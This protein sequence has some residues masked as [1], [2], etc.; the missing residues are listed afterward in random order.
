MELDQ[1]SRGHCRSSHQFTD[2]VKAFLKQMDAEPLVITLISLDFDDFNYINDLYSYEVGDMVLAQI[3]HHIDSILGDGDIFCRLHADHFLI[4]LQTGNLSLASQMFTNVTDLKQ[5]LTDFLPQHYTLAASGGIL[6]V[7]NNTLPLPALLDQA[8][9]A[10]KLSKGNITNSFHI[11]DQ[12]MNEDTCWRKQ[13]TCMM[14]AALTNHEF[15]MYLQPKVILKTG[16]VVGAEALVRWTGS[17]YGMIY[18]DRFI[19]ILEQNGFIRRLDFFMLEEA[20]RFLDDCRQRGLPIL[21][22]SVNF[23]K[24][25]LRTDRLVERIFETVKNQDISPR[26]IEIEFTES[27]LSESTERLIDVVSDLRLLGFHV[28]LDDFG[29]AYSSL[30][31]LKDLPIDIVKIDKGFLE[32]TADTDKGKI[33]IAKVVELIKSLRMMSVIEGVETAEH[34]DFLKKLSCDIAQG[35]FYARP[36]PKAD[37]ISFL[38]ISTLVEDVQDSLDGSEPA[39]SD[40]SYLHM[41]PGEFNMDNWEL[42]ILGK[43]IDMGLMKGYLDGDSTVQYVN[44]RA[45]EYLGY[46]RQEFREI[47]HNSIAGFTHPDDISKVV[48]TAEQLMAS[49]KPAQ[50]QTRGIHKDGK[51]IVFQGRASCIIDEHGRMVGLYAFQDV[52]EDLERTALLQHSL[53]HKIQELEETVAAMQA[54]RESLRQSEERYRIVVEQSNAVLF[55]WD[56]MTDTIIFSSKYRDFFGRNPHGTTNASTNP[57][58]RNFIYPDDL[59]AFEDWVNRTFKKPGRSEASFRIADNQGVYQSMELCSTAICDQQ[60]IPIKTLGTFQKQ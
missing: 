18:P 45:L 35:Y 47:C 49:G 12:K 16:D 11:Y 28:A 59:P 42:Y 30:N 43:N 33:V 27:T 55:E 22:I 41:I 44:D 40:K 31:H 26:L 24:S 5:K 48:E 56:F 29:S 37:Y 60:N 32:A 23:S 21:P 36:M 8:N 46:T 25:H 17:N 10:R 50:F 19:P 14:E 2:E 57:V 54:S 3:S 20:C 13:V 15:E 52:T 7:D 6:R 53:E 1:E 34:V 4:C 58:L 39:Q 38:N 51:V 9:C